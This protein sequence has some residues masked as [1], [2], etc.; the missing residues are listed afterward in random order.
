MAIINF[1]NL[2]K[3]LVVLFLLPS[4]KGVLI[5]LAIG[6]VKLF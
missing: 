4:I 6:L 3:E 1:V 2:E 5:T